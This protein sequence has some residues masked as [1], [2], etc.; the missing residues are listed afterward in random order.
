MRSAS[1]GS[2]RQLPRLVVANPAHGVLTAAFPH[3][4]RT[5]AVEALETTPPASPTVKAEKAFRPTATAAAALTNATGTDAVKFFAASGARHPTKFVCL[6]AEDGLR[7]EATDRAA[8][9][10]A[11]AQKARESRRFKGEAHAIPKKL[12][13]LPSRPVRDRVVQDF[14][15]YNLRK[16]NLIQSQ[17]AARKGHTIYSMTPSGLIQLTPGPGQALKLEDWTWAQSCF[18]VLRSS[19]KIFKYARE[20]RCLR[21][22]KIYTRDSIHRRLRANFE[23]KCLLARASFV[24]PILCIM[25]AAR[26]ARR[27]ELLDLTGKRAPAVEGAQSPPEPPRDFEREPETYRDKD[28]VFERGVDKE[29]M[30]LCPV[31]RARKHA[32]KLQDDVRSIADAPPLQIADPSDGHPLVGRPATPPP[33]LLEVVADSSV[34]RALELDVFEGAQESARNDGTAI[35]ERCVH[36]AADAVQHARDAAHSLVERDDVVKMQAEE[37]R[38]LDQAGGVDATDGQQFRKDLSLAEERE[39]VYER[40]ALVMRE[41]EERVLVGT[42]AE[43]ADCVLVEALSQACLSA[44][45]S[46]RDRL[47]VARATKQGLFEVHVSFSEVDHESIGPARGLGP[48]LFPILETLRPEEDEKKQKSAGA[49]AKDEGA[50]CVTS[51]GVTCQDIREADAGC[52]VVAGLNEV[53]SDLVQDELNAVLCRGRGGTVYTPPPSAV[54][55]AAEHVLHQAVDDV[56]ALLRITAMWPF[57]DD[58]EASKAGDSER[59]RC[60]PTEPAHI[61]RNR[62]LRAAEEIADIKSQ[63]ASLREE[64]QDATVVSNALTEGTAEHRGIV[65]A[66]V[67]R[68]WG[69]QQDSQVIKREILLSFEEA[70]EFVITLDEVR[71]IYDSPAADAPHASDGGSLFGDKLTQYGEHPQAWRTLAV[72]ASTDARAVFRDASR[73]ERWRLA[74]GK[75]AAKGYCGAVECSTRGLRKDLAVAVRLKRA[76]A[77]AA[78]RRCLRGHAVA[79]LSAARAL[80]A[81]LEDHP[82]SLRT[83]ARHASYVMSCRAFGVPALEVMEKACTRIHQTT[84]RAALLD[85]GFDLNVPGEDK[86]IHRDR[87]RAAL[88]KV[89]LVLGDDGPDVIFEAEASLKL[90]A[91]ERLQRGTADAAFLSWLHQ[92]LPL[93]HEEVDGQVSKCR[94]QARAVARALS[95]PRFCGADVEWYQE[96]MQVLDDVDGQGRKLDAAEDG[97]TKLQTLRSLLDFLLLEDGHVPE[98]APREVDREI[99]GDARAARAFYGRSQ[100]LWTMVARW[101][102][103]YGVWTSKPL[104]A[105]SG[106]AMDAESRL[107]ASESADLEA[108]LFEAPSIDEDYY[109]TIARRSV[110]GDVTQVGRPDLKA[111]EAFQARGGPACARLVQETRTFRDLAPVVLDLKNPNFKERHWSRVA[112]ILVPSAQVLIKIDPAET[113]L[114]DL[115]DIGVERNAADVSR[116]ARDATAEARIEASIRNM[117]AAWAAAV[118]PVV[119]LPRGDDRD[120]DDD[121]EYTY[122]LGPL[123]E[124]HA[125]ASDHRAALRAV[126]LGAHGESLAPLIAAWRWRLELLAEAMTMADG[127]ESKLRALGP[128]LDGEKDGALKHA[129]HRYR[130]VDV[131]W[132]AF[133]KSLSAAPEPARLITDEGE[134]SGKKKKHVVEA[135]A[136]GEA[137]D[138]PP[139]PSDA[140][141]NRWRDDAIILEDLREELKSHLEEKREAFPRFYYL[142]DLELATALGNLRERGSETLRYVVL[143]LPQLFDGVRSVDRAVADEEDT[144]GDRRP[145]LVGSLVDTHRERLVLL[146]PVRVWKGVEV[147]LGHLEREM[148]AA[149]RASFAEARAAKKRSA[150]H[151]AQVVLL[152]QRVNF[153]RDV[154]FAIEASQKRGDL[155]AWDDLSSRYHQ[156]AIGKATNLRTPHE[157]DDAS[158]AARS[159]NEALLLVAL[160]HR[161]CVSSLKDASKHI[162]SLDDWCWQS[163]LRFYAADPKKKK[164]KKKGADDDGDDPRTLACVAR[165]TD[166]AIPLN[167]EYVGSAR[168]TVWTPLAGRCV[169]GLTA[170][171][172]ALRGACVVGGHGCGKREL[173]ANLAGELWARCVVREP[174]HFGVACDGESLRRA[175]GHLFAGTAATGAWFVLCLGSLQHRPRGLDLTAPLLRAVAANLE[176]FVGAIAK[177]AET[178]SFA[179]RSVPLPAIQLNQVAPLPPLI[180][181]TL[182]DATAASVLD[183]GLALALRPVRLASPDVG[184]VVEGGLLA[185]GF[186]ATEASRAGADIGVALQLCL[187]AELGERP[188]KTDH[189]LARWGLRSALAV[190]REAARLKEAGDTERVCICRAARRLLPRALR[191][192]AD[193]EA[194]TLEIVDAVLGSKDDRDDDDGDAT[195]ETY[196]NIEKAFLE[197]CGGR[198][199]QIQSRGAARL[200]AATQVGCGV[201]VVGPPGC[202]KSA[203]IHAASM[204]DTVKTVV[205]VVA[206]GALPLEDCFG[207]ASGAQGCVLLRLVKLAE[208]RCQSGGDAW[209]VCDG[210]LEACWT[211]ALAAAVSSLTSKA[212]ATELAGASP[213]AVRVLIETD[214]LGHASPATVGRLGVVCVPSFRRD[215]TAAA[216]RARAFCAKHLQGADAR[217]VAVLDACLQSADHCPLD[218]ALAVASNVDTWLDRGG[219]YPFPNEAEAAHSDD[220]ARRTQGF[221]A[222]LCAL[223]GAGVDGDDADIAVRVAVAWALAWGVLGRA[224]ACGD[225]EADDGEAP[226]SSDASA[227][228]R[229][230]TRASDNERIDQACAGPA[231]RPD[232]MMFAPWSALADLG[233]ES[234]EAKRLKAPTVVSSLVIAPTKRLERAVFVGRCF[235]RGLGE[236]GVCCVEGIAGVGAT[237]IAEALC[238]REKHSF[239]RVACHATA[240]ATGSLLKRLVDQATTIKKQP[241]A[242]EDDAGSLERDAVVGPGRRQKLLLVV[243]DCSLPV[244]TA[245]SDSLVRE[246]HGGLDET[247]RALLDRGAWHDAMIDEPAAADA[248]LSGGLVPPVLRTVEGVRAI[249]VAKPIQLSARLRRHLPAV[250]LMAPDA[251]ELATVFTDTIR[252]CSPDLEGRSGDL[253]KACVS[254]AN[255]YRRLSADPDAPASL[256]P[257]LCL[258]TR[259]A[260][261]SIYLEPFQ[262]TLKLRRGLAH[263]LS[264]ELRDGLPV[265][266]RDDY[267]EAVTAEGLLAP[268]ERIVVQNDQKWAYADVSRGLPKLES[269]LAQKKLENAMADD[270]RAS[271]T[272]K[273]MST[274]RHLHANDVFDEDTNEHVP[275]SL[276]RFAAHYQRNFDDAREVASLPASPLAPLELST[277]HARHITRACRALARSGVPLVQ[278]GARGAGRRSVGDV[279]CHIIRCAEVLHAP[280]PPVPHAIDARHRTAVREGCGLVAPLASAKEDEDEDYRDPDAAWHDLL[281]GALL[282]ASRNRTVCVILSDGQWAHSST[283]ARRLDDVLAATRTG[284]VANPLIVWPEDEAKVVSDYLNSNQGQA[285]GGDAT[286]AALGAFR[287]RVK[288]AL[289]VIINIAPEDL[290]GRGAADPTATRA[291]RRLLPHATLDV[292]E[293]AHDEK[294]L[295]SIAERCVGC[296]REWRLALPESEPLVAWLARHGDD[297]RFA[298]PD[299]ADPDLAPSLEGYAARCA[300][301]LR[302]HLSAVRCVRAFARRDG[303]Q[304]RR[305]Q[306]HWRRAK[307]YGFRSLG[308]VRKAADL[309]RMRGAASQRSEAARLC[310]RTFLARRDASSPVPPPSLLAL[311]SMLALA[312]RLAIIRGTRLRAI[313]DRVRQGLEKLKQARVQAEYLRLESEA[314][315]AVAEA[316]YEESQRLNALSGST[317]AD[318]VDDALAKVNRAESIKK[319]T[320]DARERL[321]RAHTKTLG[322]S[323]LEQWEAATQSILEHRDP[324]NTLP[325]AKSIQRCLE[326]LSAFLLADEP[327]AQKGWEAFTASDFPDRCRTWVDACGR[328]AAGQGKG[329][330]TRRKAW[331]AG[332]AAAERTLNDP[333]L[334][335]SQIRKMAGGLEVGL[336]VSG[337]VRAGCQL[338]KAAGAPAS[339]AAWASLS[340]AVAADADAQR[341]LE[342]DRD[343]HR[344][345]EVARDASLQQLEDSKRVCAEA[346]ALHGDLARRHAAALERFGELEPTERRWDGRFASL[347]ARHAGLNREACAAAAVAAFAGGL[348][349]AR[350]ARSNFVEAVQRICAMTDEAPS[351]HSSLHVAVPRSCIHVLAPLSNDDVCDLGGQGGGGAQLRSWDAQGLLPGGV[352]GAVAFGAACVEAE[353]M[354]VVV[355]CDA[356]GDG[357]TWLTHAYC[358]ARPRDSERSLCRLFVDSGG[359]AAVVACHAPGDVLRRPVS[360][361]RAAAAAAARAREA[362]PP[363]ILALRE[364]VARDPAVILVDLPDDCL[365][366]GVLRALLEPLEPLLRARV[367]VVRAA[368]ARAPL[369][370]A[371]RTVYG[372]PSSVPEAVASTG[373][374]RLV[375]RIAAPLTT[376]QNS[377]GPS[378]NDCRHLLSLVD[379]APNLAETTARLAAHGLISVD[380]GPF[381]QA[382]AKALDLAHKAFLAALAARADDDD[383]LDIAIAMDPKA[384]CAAAP[385]PP[386]GKSASSA[387]FKLQ[388]KNSAPEVVAA[389]RRRSGV[390]RRAVQADERFR[391]ARAHVTAGEAALLPLARSYAA[392][393]AAVDGVCG[394]GAYGSTPA[395]ARRATAPFADHLVRFAAVAK[396][397][398]DDAAFDSASDGAE[399]RRAAFD[400]ERPRLFAGDVAPV[401]LALALR[402]AVRSDAKRQVLDGSLDVVNVVDRYRSRP[403]AS[404]TVLAWLGDGAPVAEAPACAPAPAPAAEA[405]APARDPWPDV[406]T[407]TR[408]AR[409]EAALPELAGLC[410]VIHEHTEEWRQAWGTATPERVLEA[411]PGMIPG[412]MVSK[413]LVLRCLR[414]DRFVAGCQRYAKRCL[415]DDGSSRVAVPTPAAAWPPLPEAE[416]DPGT[417]AAVAL[418][419]AGACHAAAAARPV[420]ILRS[421]ACEDDAVA[422]RPAIA[423]AARLWAAPEAPPKVTELSLGSAFRCDA[424]SRVVAEARVTG[425]WV[426]LRHAQLCEAWLPALLAQYDMLDAQ[427]ADRNARFR[428]Q[429]QTFLDEGKGEKQA[430]ALARAAEPCEGVRAGG[431]T[432]DVPAPT[433]HARHRLILELIVPPFGVCR[434]PRDLARR[435]V[436][437]AT[438]PPSSL[439]QRL[440]W[441]FTDGGGALSSTKLYQ[442]LSDAQQRIAY[443]Q[444][445]LHALIRTRRDFGGRGFGHRVTPGRAAWCAWA[446]LAVRQA[447]GASCG[448]LGKNAASTVSA[449]GGQDGWGLTFD[450]TRGERRGGPSDDGDEPCWSLGVGDRFPSTEAARAQLVKGCGDAAYANVDH[451]RLSRAERGDSAV[452]AALGRIALRCADATALLEVPDWARAPDARGQKS[453]DGV[454]AWIRSLDDHEDA[455][456]VGFGAYE[457]RRVD[458]CAADAVAS[459]AARAA[460]AGGG[461]RHVRATFLR[462]PGTLSAASMAATVAAVA[463]ACRGDPCPNEGGSAAWA[464]TRRRERKCFDDLLDTISKTLA[465]QDVRAALETGLT[466]TEWAAATRHVTRLQG[467]AYSLLDGDER[468]AAARVPKLNDWLRHLRRLRTQFRAWPRRQRPPTVWA[469]GLFRPAAFFAQLRGPTLFP[470]LASPATGDV[471][472]GV[473]VRGLDLGGGVF[474]ADGVLGV[475]D[476]APHAV[477]LWV[478]GGHD[479]DG[480]DLPVYATPTRGELCATL[481]VATG[482]P[483]DLALRGCALVIS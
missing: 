52:E 345:A 363:L 53:R 228:L 237:T 377:L 109:R 170:C 292:Y 443:A 60:L 287:D 95:G 362:A 411:H 158:R 144:T 473:L 186:H 171:M 62:W 248:A 173:V 414:P 342:V 103:V 6:V 293:G 346:E 215:A 388:A 93:A 25:A 67:L 111:D 242:D 12:S 7:R 236:G 151:C 177:K 41:R 50:W 431:V 70:N 159:K 165:Q 114:G 339:L 262:S 245:D 120:A 64:S 318:A 405:P 340:D 77:R 432:Y 156:D 201:A 290:R 263:E 183:H 453:W 87:K 350:N 430:V 192:A 389:A 331:R 250:P 224:L 311:R 99:A 364:A 256:P 366:G 324:A 415:G 257:A 10:E 110:P 194:T 459:Q 56:D 407:R 269:R 115:L 178:V 439:K 19:F 335:A 63:E 18:K 301:A 2:Q 474:A 308:N 344:A 254:C 107:F 140:K 348:P 314:A 214:Q 26:E 65:K 351:F 469:P 213:V 116:I 179:G 452:L 209:I 394:P 460:T 153:T 227:W 427:V 337:W 302:T 68:D 463:K 264:R 403:G 317:C 176:V 281:R 375:F 271:L 55:Q 450:A 152:V 465:Q 166:C 34:A 241:Y 135:V 189:L 14:Q 381:V 400:L 297:P 356:L 148:R 399:A 31:A 96:P 371:L 132:R 396:H 108:R 326:A 357:A 117:A 131:R 184:R 391:V 3:L 223:L 157:S 73:F 310:V 83:Y 446:T 36:R 468:A 480:Y 172:R 125:L 86:A 211:E 143:A 307:D 27:V 462:K 199:T 279:A 21:D 464:A 11:I 402:A 126:A 244:P 4:K 150:T 37:Q 383:V 273:G 294:A 455:R 205:A 1:A 91:D 94:G 231:P 417:A 312:M 454:V 124:L 240:T 123:D 437:V 447:P 429:V 122:E 354:R 97:R 169:L 261:G 298:R 80:R 82:H 319:R 278:A 90:L 426:L 282:D 112:K 418:R 277:H 386:P 220:D 145:Q 118:V 230:H 423:A 130:S 44:T 234:N 38:L 134:K 5:S 249:I 54:Q 79:A 372:P 195:D 316:R 265:A 210:P 15:P 401:A 66:I 332:L 267:D 328:A 127:L 390:E 349:L 198:P 243:D 100:L 448:D 42:L 303:L 161:E 438:A 440:V 470:L 385:K 235:L 352:D 299:D 313:E 321:A 466:P 260:R 202:G 283:T 425:G 289:R 160:Q 76:A 174:S 368:T 284:T 13:P 334:A 476:G 217:L 47:D 325:A 398:D 226:V 17:A 129:Y 478:R 467:D 367:D 61:C 221:A 451:A 408:L 58:V 181:V 9:F 365:T 185:R 43:L 404:V 154:E 315:K 146:N 275:P 304:V 175:V 305:I 295:V 424:A 306:R 397:C 84:R 133:L 361:S 8:S 128:T 322:A 420:L 472:H 413:L 57:C 197:K 149:L 204:A 20:L 252:A 75:V 251:D 382:H 92:R 46:F 247:L 106:T 28:A 436:V 483:E 358:R 384:L 30:H 113:S 341:D 369:A 296:G 327:R 35:L 101:Q 216:D 444:V 193:D 102:Q 395:R 320:R 355:M 441:G 419:V 45:T 456:R 155:S 471:P 477:M 378:A 373:G 142:T 475:R 329:A 207:T 200:L 29:T 163:V 225:G 74:L 412:D 370:R 59:R 78:A 239:K 141:L 164:K 22:W 147:W 392:V 433:P 98:P 121:D 233:R 180:C 104:T 105:F 270:G 428:E 33:K 48:T 380:D 266:M 449:A 285:D 406:A 359:G 300:E 458:A 288:R 136:G 51:G 167:L 212:I 24:Q 246:R 409:V 119:A 343:G 435:C 481:R 347:A 376:V 222:L 422:L 323:T 393:V 482:C 137:F 434:A 168:R 272:K 187:D 72:A 374:P 88:E 232:L 268:S 218:G 416:A 274:S 253:A 387:Q 138:M 23:N 188:G 85:D 330:A 238:A 410:D 280:P 286:T 39:I 276:E 219:A 190:V 457:A 445:L 338:F 309:V 49:P 89:S 479:E 32:L 206:P 81:L 333:A 360:P 162:T 379:F 139:K 353:M 196:A 229:T 203:I 208:R 442:R 16:V 69:F 40:R 461:W 71:S 291:L 255:V 191:G 259:V 336:P 421:A 182:G 258:A